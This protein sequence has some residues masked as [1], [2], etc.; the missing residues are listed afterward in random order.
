M[1]APKLG[2][3][4]EESRER[5]LKFKTAKQNP[6]MAQALI[7]DACM[8]EGEGARKDLAEEFIRKRLTKDN[9]N[10]STPRVGYTR[11]YEDSWSNIFGSK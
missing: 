3:Y 6:N 9:N 8:H 5:L 4:Y 11:S 2:M 10:H 1:R 7:D